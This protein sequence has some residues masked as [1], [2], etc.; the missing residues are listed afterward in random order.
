MY[1]ST[2]CNKIEGYHEADGKTRYEPLPE[3]II[4]NSIKGS[5]INEIQED[6]EDK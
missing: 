2:P 1:L 3:E 6:I 4:H 5:L